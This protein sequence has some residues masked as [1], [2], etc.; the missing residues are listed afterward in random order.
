MLFQETLMLLAASMAVD[1]SQ[2]LMPTPPM[3]F[4]NWARFECALNQTIFTETADAMVSKGLVKAGYDR[5][6][7][8]DCWPLHERA[9]NGSLQWD[10]EKFPNGLIWLGQYLKNRNLK[11]GIYSDAGNLTCGGYPGSL[12]Y[13]EIDAETFSS[14]GIDYLKLDGCNVYNQ[15]SLDSEQTYKNIYGHWHQVILNMSRP[16]IFSESA[17]AYFSGEANLTDWYLVMD[18]VPGYGELACHSNDIATFDTPN[19]W[20]S[21]L[22]NYG[23]EI[24]LARYQ[25]PGYFNDPDF[26]IVDHANLTLDEKKSHFALWASFSAPLIIS[27]YIPDLTDDEIAYLTNEDLIAI[28]QDALGLQATLVSQDGTW[29]VLS[30]SLSNG[31][32]LLTILNRGDE[33]GSLSVPFERLGYPSQYS[34]IFVVKDLWT[35]ATS[36]VSNQI[37]ANVPSHGTA[38][39]RVSSRLAAIPTGMIFNTAS[40]NCLTANGSSVRWTKCTGSDTQIWQITSGRSISSLSDLS[41][42]LS[43]DAKSGTV[44]LEVCQGWHKSQKWDYAITGNVQ[45][46]A[47]SD[48]LTEGQDGVVTL[49]ECLVENNS[50]VFELPSGSLQR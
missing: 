2:A 19:P 28:D 10:P 7:I 15:G 9:A 29:D 46:Q 39:F 23:F 30:K 48:C 38:V 27:A 18:W 40:L 20:E 37:T 50:Q 11:F 36:E 12:N 33:A 32:R 35:G 25:S 8:D 42:C 14:W 16:L 43:R 24:L 4:N 6:N 44:A 34:G 41:K 22:T 31:D 26:L 13:E 3:G 49:V 17:P 45:N 47:S 21:I 5:V 1:A